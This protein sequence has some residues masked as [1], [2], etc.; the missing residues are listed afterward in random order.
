MDEYQV[1]VV[2]H[3]GKAAF[4]RIPN[5]TTFWDPA[6]PDRPIA[7]GKYTWHTVVTARTSVNNKKASLKQIQELTDKAEDMLAKSRW[8]YDLVAVISGMPIHLRTNSTHLANFWGQNWYLGHMNEVEKRLGKA[9]ITIRA[10]LDPT[11]DLTNPAHREALKPTSSAY[12]CPENRQ[13]VFLNTDYYGQCK[14]WGLGAAGVGLADFEIHSCHGACVDIDGV[15]VVIIAPTGTGKSTYTNWL[16]RYGKINSDDWVYIQQEGNQFVAN[17]SERYIYVRSNA[18]R[19]NPEAGDNPSLV[20]EDPVMRQQF[21]IFERHPAENVPIVSRRR[22]YNR[23]PNS[24][25]MINPADIAPMSYR[26]PINLVLLLRRDD[27][28]PYIEE[29]DT[30]EALEILRKGEF[31]VAPGATVDPNEIG[32]LKNE[33]WYNPYLLAPDDAFEAERFAAVKDRGGAGYLVIN[34]S[35]IYANTGKDGKPDINE[36]IE[37]T[38]HHILEHVSRYSGKSYR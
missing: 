11:K 2:F 15:G 3:D 28:S 1:P 18:V 14:S 6:G 33:S 17:P 30:K 32:T 10:A 37:R 9:P 12:F 29:L 8:T 4:R 27:V 7:P 21:E 20:Q 19:D 26:T 38:G 13:I 5:P 31:M 16:A 25:V 36:L 34:T 23:I 22:M 24:R 35:S